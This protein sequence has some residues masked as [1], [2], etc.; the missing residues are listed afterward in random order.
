MADLDGLYQDYCGAGM[1]GIFRKLFEKSHILNSM[2]R[3][4]TREMVESAPL[5]TSRTNLFP[6]MTLTS[7]MTV[8]ELIYSMI[9]MRESC[10]P[11]G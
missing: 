3:S 7:H 11:S 1:C 10:S 4:S 9:P 2:N 5:S 6:S 8:K